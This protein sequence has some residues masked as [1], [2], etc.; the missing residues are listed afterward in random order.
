MP[1]ELPDVEVFR[2][3]AFLWL[4]ANAS[5]RSAHPT[6]GEDDEMEWGVGSDN[7]AVFH[8][9][10]E[11]EERA[12]L[13][14]TRDWQ[15]KKF[16][17]GY[18]MINWPAELGGR[19]LPSSYLR[20]YN[21]EEA[22]FVTPSA[23]ELPPTSMGLI[24][25]TVA[26][27]GTPEQKRRL[28]EP[29]M[30][31]DEL[32]CQLF[33]EPSAGSD[34]ASLT[35]RAARDGDEWVL[36]GQKVWTSGARFADWGLAITRTDF[37][38]PKHRGLTAFMVPFV[39]PGVEVRPIRRCRAAANF[40]EVFLT[41]VRLG[42]DL[43]LGPVGEGWRRGPDLPRLRARPLRRRRAA[44]TSAAASSGCCSRRATSAS[45]TSPGC[46]RPWPTSTSSTAWPR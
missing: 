15:R 28:I 17:A 16:D 5:L 2:K 8:N 31:M 34:L 26:A 45:P 14:A 3:E 21:T 19:G 30:R 33:S 13:E 9:F 22:K 38:V 32:A 4:E 7:V 12:R 29:L 25:T 41:D 39:A 11:D 44:A 10:S 35:T 23:G 6:D 42:D 20:A 24:A 1:G 36:N 27:Y 43:R 40:N 37:D 46:A 18:A